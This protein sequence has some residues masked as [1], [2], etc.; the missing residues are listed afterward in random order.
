MEKYAN[1]LSING[2]KP[3]YRSLFREKFAQKDFYQR[4]E[5]KDI[6][7]LELALQFVKELNALK[8]EEL[9]MIEKEI[10]DRVEKKTVA[11]G[12]QF[13]THIIKI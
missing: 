4:E 8:Y 1:Y 7:K 5:Q 6:E 13:K 10:K 2:H 3:L 11:P 9:K 12:E